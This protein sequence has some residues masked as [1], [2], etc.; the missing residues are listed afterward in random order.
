MMKNTTATD[1]TQFWD[2][3]S[4]GKL[5]YARISPNPVYIAKRDQF[6]YRIRFLLKKIIYLNF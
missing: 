4:F 6:R 3:I 2:V 5:D 1:H